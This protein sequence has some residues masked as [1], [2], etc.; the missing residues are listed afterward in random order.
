MSNKEEHALIGALVGFGGYVIAKYMLN[1]EVNWGNALCWGA[2]GAG[3]ALVPDILEPA[4]S[5]NHRAIAHSLVTGG[6]L[7][8]TTKRVWDSS[9]LNSEQKAGASAL[10]GAYLSHLV[11][12][13]MTPAG[14]PVL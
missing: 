4:V 9:E 7:L 13:S 2:V 1:E 3:V 10:I 11:A 6:A 12:D 14:L 5:P 8:Y